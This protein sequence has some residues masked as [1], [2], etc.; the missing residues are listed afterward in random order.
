MENLSQNAF[1]VHA[2]R[3]YLG[4]GWNLVGMGGGVG[5][6]EELQLLTIAYLSKT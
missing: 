6:L 2:E 5:M 1:E 4:T 3:R